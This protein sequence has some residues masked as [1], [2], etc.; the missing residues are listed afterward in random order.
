M[1]PP[2]SAPDR[3]RHARIAPKGTV[4]IHALGNA[5]R[6]RLVNIGVGGMYVATGVSLPDRLLGR[7]VDLELRFDRAL[8]AWQRLTGRISRIAADGPAIVFAAPTAP[9]LLL[10]IDKLTTASHA[11]ARVIS[12]VLIDADEARRAV[13]AAGFRATGC[14]VVEAATQ[15][16]AI[17][18]LG[19]CDFE[20][21]IIA[22]ANT[23]P[24]TAADEMRAFVEHYH[25]SSMLVTIGPE[26]L[27]PAGLANWLSEATATADL[28][29]RIREL[30]FAP[31]GR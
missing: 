29:V 1:N 6:G 3:R 18:R 16:E 11:S 4:T 20:P 21:D 13:I 22:V 12:V 23:Q 25:P 26:L 19:E 5:H 30:L 15:L 27:D 10:V 2:G 24:V 9:A 14:E 28:P 8:A 7:V 31:R 17:V